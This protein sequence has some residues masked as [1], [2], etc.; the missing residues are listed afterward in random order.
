M[1]IDDSEKKLTT[2]EAIEYLGRRV[3]E[4]GTGNAGSEMGAVE[5]LA[6]QI[7]KGLDGIGSGLEALADAVREHGK[8]MA[9]RDDA[10]SDAGSGET[11]SRTDFDHR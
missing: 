8:A 11:S 6:V 1:L 2:A 9:T 3:Q 7:K 10:G 5:Y 4:L